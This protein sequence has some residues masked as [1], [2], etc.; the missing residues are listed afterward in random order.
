WLQQDLPAR[1]SFE[2]YVPAIGRRL[3]FRR[4]GITS[5]DVVFPD[6]SMDLEALPVLS[7]DISHEEFRRL[8]PSPSNFAVNFSRIEDVEDSAPSRLTSPELLWGWL[9]SGL[10]AFMHGAQGLTA[11]LLTMAGFG[12]AVMMHELGHGLAA[13]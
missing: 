8:F 13:W 4:V 7:Q 10:A 5:P 12:A 2:V 3:T 1:Q 9:I 6:S 11:W